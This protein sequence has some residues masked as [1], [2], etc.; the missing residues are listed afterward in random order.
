MNEIT[1][2]EKNKVSLDGIKKIISI[3][4]KHVELELNYATV[5][6]TGENIEIVHINEA[7]TE[8]NLKGTIKEVIFDNGKVKNKGSFF[9]HLFE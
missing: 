6:I 2:T 4:A 5:T 3:T 7:Q 8:I 1:I 9:K